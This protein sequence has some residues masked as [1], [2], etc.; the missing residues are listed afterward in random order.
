MKRSVKLFLLCI[1]WVMVISLMALPVWAKPMAKDRQIPA[2]ASQEFVIESVG[3]P[4]NDDFADAT[5][6]EGES[7]TASGHTYDA[8]MEEGEPNPWDD[9]YKP[10]ASVWWSWQATTSGTYAFDST[11]ADPESESSNYI[12]V[13]T[14]SSLTELTL[15]AGNEYVDWDTETIDRVVFK[16]V[17]GTTYY[18]SVC[19]DLNDPIMIDLAWAKVT[20]PDN[21][22]FANATLINTASGTGYSSNWNATAEPEEIQYLYAP[23]EGFVVNSVWWQW[24][25]PATGS[26][27]F[28]TAG[29]GMKD[30]ML[31]IY[32]GTSYETLS[33]IIH[34]DDRPG[35]TWSTAKVDATGGSS[36]YVCVIGYW[37]CKG[38][39]TLNWQESQAPSITSLNATTFEVGSEG[40]FTLTATG[41]PAPD[42]LLT[43]GTLPTDVYYFRSDKTLTGTPAAGTGGVYN[44]LFTATNGVGDNATQ[45]FTLTVNEAPIFTSI[46][47]AN[48]AIGIPVSF[49]IM[50]SGY[51]APAVELTSGTLPDGITYDPTT[52]LLSGTATGAPGAYPLVFTASNG[53]GSPVTQSFSL[54]TIVAK[55]QITLQPHSLM[56]TIGET[57][58]FSVDATGSPVLTYQWQVCTSARKNIWTD[59]VGETSSVYTTPAATLKMNGYQYRVVVANAAGSV[60]SDPAMLTVYETSTSQSNVE[61]DVIGAYDNASTTIEWTIGVSSLGPENAE[62]VQVTA[63]LA[64]FSRFVSADLA[65]IPG[66]TY[67]VQG[68]KVMVNLGTLS[69]NCEFT[70]TTD[71]SRAT[72][73]TAL[74]VV[75]TTT[76]FDPD[77]SNNTATDEVIWP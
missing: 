56:A 24:T 9:S 55:P 17:A 50:A 41:I 18:I 8:T 32:S 76:S 2:T 20:P 29:S 60:T 37:G 40:T 35:D 33:L 6:L 73:P 10:E 52:Q 42:I 13:Y 51:P 31:D 28:D 54:A 62:A 19:A 69:G 45:N 16:A 77:L 53:V 66:A 26:F 63:T 39:I 44:L 11:N 34:N 74:T 14:G 15:L 71:I 43:S 47:D 67:K 58:T 21:D 3:A 1:V 57:A 22:D 59:L 64:K 36:Y 48:F 12:V 25:A 4:I 75:A 46:S 30:T 49:S 68:S 72:S 27:T 70:L 38:E 7:G 5:V 61:I 23:D 65:S